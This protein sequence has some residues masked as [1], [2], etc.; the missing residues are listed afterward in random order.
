MSGDI[1]PWLQHFYH[2]GGVS[3]SSHKVTSYSEMLLQVW[4][5]PLL[6]M[7][8]SLPHHHLSFSLSPSS[9]S[10]IPSPLIGHPHSSLLPPLFFPR[11]VMYTLFIGP[12][13][14]FSE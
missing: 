8:S 4:L 7:A 1:C 11:S 3:Q 5:S 6:S 9:P 14:H 12:Q 2:E 13:G 10:F